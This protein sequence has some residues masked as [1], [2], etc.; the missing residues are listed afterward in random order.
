MAPPQCTFMV[1]APTMTTMLSQLSTTLHPS[2]HTI[3]LLSLPLHPHQCIRDPS[4]KFLPPHLHHPRSQLNLPCPLFPLNPH[5]HLSQH[6]LLIKHLIKSTTHLS[7]TVN[8]NM[9]L[10]MPVD[11]T[12]MDIMAMAMARRPTL[13]LRPT[14]GMLLKAMEVTDTAISMNT[15]NPNMATVIKMDMEL[16]ILED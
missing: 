16:T 9:H 8:K 5:L 12:V 7:T 4:I 10:I 14:L 15:V 3:L 6:L 13:P 1:L 2:L 11:T